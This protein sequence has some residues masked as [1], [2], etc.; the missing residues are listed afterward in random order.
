MGSRE[1][2]EADLNNHF[3]RYVDGLWN[4]DEN[5]SK[6]IHIKRISSKDFA[7]HSWRIYEDSKIVVII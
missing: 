2:I 1:T 4:D 5:P 6:A 7:K 3:S